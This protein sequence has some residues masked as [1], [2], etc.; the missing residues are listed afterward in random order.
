MRLDA[1]GVK[2]VVCVLNK[3]IEPVVLAGETE[4]VHAT[5][6]SVE[7]AERWHQPFVNPLGLP[8]LEV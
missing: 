5:V 6:E 7:I 1:Q 4:L 3:S 2:N 8:R